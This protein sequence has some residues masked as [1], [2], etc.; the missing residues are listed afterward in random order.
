[1]SAA[2]VIAAPNAPPTGDATVHAPFGTSEIV[3]TTTSRLAGAIHSLTWN[4]REFID[5]FDHGRQLQSASSFDNRPDANPETFNPTEAGSRDDDRGPTSTSRLRELTA[6]KN[7][8]RTVSQMAFW[9]KPGERSAGQLARNTENLSHHLLTKEV[10]IGVPGLPNVLDYTAT[11]TLPEGEPHATAQF[12]A[13]TGYM[14]PDFSAFW[15]FNRTTG[16]LEPLS[17]GPG[18]IADPVVLATPDGQ[19]AMGI[20]STE[21]PADHSTGPTYGR[22]R[23]VPEK[24][25]KWNCVFRLGGGVTPGPHR[26]HMFI[27]LGTRDD[28]EAALRTLSAPK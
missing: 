16:H 8:L 14:P 1:M 10:R 2:G 20:I 17:D 5:S 3:I 6:E 25:V 22:F 27:P 24:V 11:F 4:G 19:H 21:P 13:L 18:E 28:V 12:E 15:R 26:Y 7:F 23:F 9:L